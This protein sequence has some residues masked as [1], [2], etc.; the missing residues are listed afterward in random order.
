[1]GCSLL[2]LTPLFS[3]PFFS[4]QASV[5]IRAVVA[6]LRPVHE[7]AA[8]PALQPRLIEVTRAAGLGEIR[9][10][11]REHRLVGSRVGVQSGVWVV[12]LAGG[13]CFGTRFVGAG[14]RALAVPPVARAVL[15]PERVVDGED[16][17]PEHLMVGTGMGR[18]GRHPLEVGEHVRLADKLLP[19]GCLM[20]PDDRH[21]V[22][23]AEPCPALVGGDGQDLVFPLF[24]RL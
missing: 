9:M 14:E 15:V 11:L 17:I 24:E 21:V 12:R 1:M 10:A 19:V 13:G 7:H 18:C 22:F 6:I 8:Q 23:G 16:G 2:L 4:R 3:Y 5:Y 20:C